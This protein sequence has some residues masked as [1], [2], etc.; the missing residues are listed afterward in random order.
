[1]PRSKHTPVERFW[2]QVDQSNGPDS[3][4]LWTGGTR[5]QSR[6]YGSMS[7]GDRKILVHRFSWELACGPIPNGMRVLHTC[8]NPPCVNPSHLFLGTQLD[9]IADRKAKGR[10]ANGSRIPHAVLTPGIVKE[11]RQRLKWYDRT[12][13]CAALAK[14][15]GV[16]KTTIWQAAHGK[17]WKNIAD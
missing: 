16:G 13:G 14:E 6:A 7:V 5:D 10:S 1:M 11:I 12:D 17:S 3:C 15:F 9:N 8:D 2:L 4:W